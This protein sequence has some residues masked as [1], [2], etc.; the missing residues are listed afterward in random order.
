VKLAD[1]AQE[2]LLAFCTLT[3]DN[4]FVVRD[5]K[6]IEG[7]KGPFV[8]MPSRKVTA[9]CPRCRDKN[10]LRANYCNAC[11][12][13]LSPP[14]TLDDGR[15]RPRLYVDTAHPINQQCRALIEQAAIGAY[16]E[17][18]RRSKMPGYVAPDLDD[19]DDS[20]VTS[21]NTRRRRGPSSGSG[22]ESRS[23]GHSNGNGRA[24]QDGA[25]H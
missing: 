4:A 12:E 10:H 7:P 16:Q 22:T 6:V 9:R 25:S 8:A 20:V 19:F 2:R 17:E 13:S 14:A 23:G 18:L 24:A 21:R 15:G 5:V 3:F 11:G 1:N